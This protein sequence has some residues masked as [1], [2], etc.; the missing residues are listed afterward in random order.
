M[1]KAAHCI[2]YFEYTTLSVS[3]FPKESISPVRKILT[4][5]GCNA[6]MGSL[7]FNY[8]EQGCVPFWKGCSTQEAL[9]EGR[10]WS[11]HL[12]QGLW[13]LWRSQSSRHRSVAGSSLNTLPQAI[14]IIIFLSTCLYLCTG[15][16]YL[17]SHEV[18]IFLGTYLGVQRRAE[19]IAITVKPAATSMC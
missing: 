19:G 13:H 15:Q 16:I 8:W 1:W 10:H 11:A 4:I 2:W 14:F 3:E 7:H 17:M 12:L 9:A 18:H 6:K 5:K